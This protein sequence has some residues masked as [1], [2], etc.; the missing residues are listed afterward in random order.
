VLYAYAGAGHFVGNL[1]PYEP[2]ARAAGSDPSYAA[3]Q[4]AD[5]LLWPHLL[6]FLAELAA[7]PAG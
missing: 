4:E 5:A 3:D 1:L 2:E 6:H 7:R